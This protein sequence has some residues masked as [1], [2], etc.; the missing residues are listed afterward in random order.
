MTID[1]IAASER[2]TVER[3][4]APVLIGTTLLGWVYYAEGL[5]HWYAAEALGDGPDHTEA[6][7]AECIEA[8][9]RAW[10]ATE[11]PVT[12]LA[13]ELPREIPREPGRLRCPHC[14]ND[15]PAQIMWEERITSCREICGLAGEHVL[16]DAASYQ[17]DPGGCTGDDE[18]LCC[19][20]CNG[21]FPVPSGMTIVHD[22]V[23]GHRQ[24]YGEDAIVARY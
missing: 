22:E 11:R 19:R 15:D 3:N 5:F 23:A 2:L 6:S 20:N 9:V 1:P 7:A 10:K 4:Q 8:L 13:G 21:F 18:R 24:V 17:D 12:T 14:G 16:V